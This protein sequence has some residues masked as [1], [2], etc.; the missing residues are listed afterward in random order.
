MLL[1]ISTTHQPATDLGFLLYKNPANI[2]TFE[3]PCGQ[4]YVFYPEKSAERC[5][6]ALLLD[7]DPIS[8]VRGRKGSQSEG[9]LDQYVN[10]RPYVASS[11]LSVAIANVFGS[12][13]SGKCRERPELIQTAIPLEVSISAVECRG[14]EPLLRRLFE[15]LG[16]SLEVQGYKLDENFDDWGPSKYYSLR[17]AG[18]CTLHDLLTHIY[19][20]VPVLDND[21]H[22]F[23]DEAEMEKLL[24]HGEGW[25]ANHPERNYITNR[26]L[27]NKK[28]LTR[29]ALERLAEEDDLDPDASE[30]KNSNE[31]A[32]VEKTISLNER[33]IGTVLA[34]L[35]EANARRVIDLGCGEGKLIGNFLKERDF[36]EIVGMD[37][38]YRALETASDRLHLDRM[39]AREKARLKLMQGSL[40]YRDKRL[41]GFDAATCIEVIEH[42]DP[43]R[44]S[45]FERVLFEFAQPAMVVLTTPNIEYNSKFATLPPGQLRHRDHRFEW[46]RAEFQNWANN[47][48]SR[49]GYKVRFLP[50]GDE[51][52]LVGSP[53]QMGI[54]KR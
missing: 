37:V 4:A 31:E 43:P 1:T 6:A 11:F 54:F 36:Q 7:I 42:L 3:L 45:S 28:R 25:L 39:P 9:S 24:R 49:F 50:I 16:Y 27:Q 19:V 35:K 44:L 26:Y 5:T 29:L 22:Y 33:R 13:L 17:L 53:T 20:M 14:G 38:S 34:V 2:H 21:K 52:P 46:T 23:V 48:C 51:D 40:T 47:I 30:E 12:A 10:D 32:A 41:S 15:P 8:L 18:N